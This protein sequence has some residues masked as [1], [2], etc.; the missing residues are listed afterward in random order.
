M[1]PPLQ[2][3]LTT[4]FR[5][6]LHT[7]PTGVIALLVI[8]RTLAARQR[9]RENAQTGTGIT[10][11][12]IAAAIPEIPTG[13]TRGGNIRWIPTVDV[14]AFPVKVLVSGEDEVLVSVTV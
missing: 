14:E 6:D 8:G 13:S 7:I 12:R 3:R 11:T 10:V 1:R 5:R 4:R 2:I 9:P